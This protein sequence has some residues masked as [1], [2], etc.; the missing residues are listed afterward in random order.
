MKVENKL[1]TLEE[2]EKGGGK[3][4]MALTFLVFI[5]LSTGGKTT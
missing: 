2:K 4:E 3:D 1:H 5:I